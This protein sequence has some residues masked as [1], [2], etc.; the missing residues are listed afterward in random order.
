MGAKREKVTKDNFEELLLKSVSEGVAHVKGERLVEKLVTLIEEPPRYSKGKIKKIRAELG[1]S[2]STFAKIF[3]ESTSAIQ[4]WEQGR[5]NISKSA[6]RLLDLI[7]KDPKTVLG[8][9]TSQKAS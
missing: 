5:R 8:L 9:I 6:R 2:Q 4:H 1:V 3:A 7:E